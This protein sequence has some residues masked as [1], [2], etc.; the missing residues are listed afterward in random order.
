MTGLSSLNVELDAKRLAL[1]KEAIPRLARV[2][3]LVNPTE[4]RG[5]MLA[6]TE[7]ARLGC[8][9]TSSRSVPVPTWPPP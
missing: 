1:L 8:G 5:A 2:A 7:G 4:P 6:A 9:C 3:V